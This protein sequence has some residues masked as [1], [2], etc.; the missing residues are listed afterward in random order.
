MKLVV[1]ASFAFLW[2]GGDAGAPAVA[3][4]DH[5]YRAGQLELH[6]PELFVAETAN[7]LW[8]AVRRG[9][10]TLDESVAIFESLQDLRISLHTHR[11]LAA[12]AL[13]LAMR[14]GI[15]AGDAMYVALALRDSTPLFTADARLARAVEDI[16]EVITA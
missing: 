6:A 2:L 7:V 16:L 10:R 9:L 1:D 12:P 3:E 8:K 14:R 13:D 5:R 11:D 15:P 4:F